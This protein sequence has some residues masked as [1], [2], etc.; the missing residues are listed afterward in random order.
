[1]ICKRLFGWLA[2]NREPE[3]LELTDL[4]RHGDKI[5]A[6]RVES[7]RARSAAHRKRMERYRNDPLMREARR[8]S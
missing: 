5:I 2:P 1:M 4:V 6:S 8:E 7:E 3:P